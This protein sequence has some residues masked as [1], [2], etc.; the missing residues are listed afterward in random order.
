M[1]MMDIKNLNVT[2]KMCSNVFLNHD[3][4]PFSELF[5]NVMIKWLRFLQFH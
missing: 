2:M 3:D 4:Y 5:N 1:M